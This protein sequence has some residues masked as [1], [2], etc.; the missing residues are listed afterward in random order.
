MSIKAEDRRGTISAAICF[1]SWYRNSFHGYKLNDLSIWY[2]AIWS[3]QMKGLVNKIS[4]LEILPTTGLLFFMKKR[5]EVDAPLNA[6]TLTEK[7]G[8]AKTKNQLYERRRSQRR[9]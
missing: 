9:Y 5:F 1:V 7:N 8:N 6:N 2:L 4:S 3:L